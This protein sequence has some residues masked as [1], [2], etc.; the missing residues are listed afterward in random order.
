MLPDESDKLKLADEFANFFSNKILNIRQS[1]L[2][3]RNFGNNIHIE[4]TVKD[5]IFPFSAFEPIDKESVKCMI[6]STKDKYS[7]ID[8]IP[9]CMI[10]KTIYSSS[11][12]LL[13][14]INYCFSHGVFP[15]CLKLSHIT[16][17]VKS[18][19]EDLEMFSN[20]RPISILSFLSK[21]IEKCVLVQLLNHLD[22][23]NLSYHYQ[24]AYKSY[25]SCETALLKIYDDI[26]HMLDSRSYVF[27]LFLDFSSAFDT[28]DHHI[29]LEKLE[30]NFY[31]KG[32]ALKWFKSF[33]SNRQFKV[34]VEGNF[35]KHYSANYGVPQGSVLG[36]ILFSLYSQEVSKIIESYGFNVHMFAD[37]I[38]IYFQCDD[39]NSKLPL[40][41]SCFNEIK[42]W[43]NNNFLK[44]NDKKTKLLVISSKLRKFNLP[45]SLFENYCCEPSVRNLGFIIDRERETFGAQH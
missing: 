28:V 11:N 2:M 17:I 18:M 21:L 8:D 23:N 33:L 32:M 13:D 16:P 29:L 14:I 6:D 20:Y 24:S 25:H 38:Q 27:M 5:N 3:N 31:V 7:S 15:Q 41:K 40:L 1:I 4:T 30:K 34:N 22:Q 10:R 44:L 45:T 39:L 9:Q 43:A 36:P 26:L 35:S 19:K 37:D 12:Y 42:L